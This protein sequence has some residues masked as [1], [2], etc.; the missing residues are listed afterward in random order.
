MS[1]L[2]RKPWPRHHDRPME[3]YGYRPYFFSCTAVGCNYVEMDDGE[4][5]YELDPEPVTDSS[6]LV[7]VGILVICSVIAAALVSL[8]YILR[9]TNWISLLAI[10][11]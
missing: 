1:Y 10:F 7:T 5:S 6:A 4:M 3:R 8:S 2:P 11:L 9:R